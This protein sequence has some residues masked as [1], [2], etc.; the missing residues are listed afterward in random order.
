M[1]KRLTTTIIAAG[2]LGLGGVTSTFV[3][4]P[5]VV[6]AATSD[7]TTSEALADRVGGIRDALGGLVQ[8]GTLTDPQADKVAETLAD[9]LPGHH[10]FGHGGPG[11]HLGDVAEVLDLT[12]EELFSELRDGRSL[13]DIA[14]DQ[15][16]GKQELIDALV[17]LASERIDAAVDD[18]RLTDA[19]AD[20]MK[21]DL[22]A[23]I[24]DRVEQQGMQGSRGGMFHH[25]G[26]PNSDWPGGPG[27]RG[28]G[29]GTS[30]TMFE[31]QL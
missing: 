26:G 29:P 20:Q 11:G 24:T 3:L 17:T 15:G 27:V 31:T 1:K 10:G 19:Q 18:G 13:E 22:A 2:A 16:I 6:S 9:Q 25:R 8:D 28:D 23:R 5:A 7:A 14:A 4:A 30:L 21:S 12:E